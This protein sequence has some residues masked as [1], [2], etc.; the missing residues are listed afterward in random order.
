MKTA[1]ITGGGGFIG[2]HLAHLLLTEG[3]R[4]RVLDNFS[5][6]TPTNL[7]ALSGP[8]D[9]IN[10]DICDSD[11]C[12]AAT[13]GVDSV[14]H[15][16]A[17]A[18]VA[19]SV[20]DPLRS[21]A[22]NLTGTVQ[23]LQAAKEAGVRR[24]VFSS[25]ASVY[26]NAETVPT[27]EDQLI[28]PLSPY[29]STK[30]SGEMYCRNYFDL[31]GMETVILRYFNVFGPRQSVSSGYAAAIPIFIQQILAGKTPTIYGDGRQTRDFVYVEDV[32]AAN[33]RAALA[34]GVGGQVFNIAGGNS[35]TLLDLMSVLGDVTG[36]AVAPHF[37]PARSGD[38]R[39]SRADISR[40]RALLGYAPAVSFTEGIC[41][42][43][44]QTR[45][46]APAQPSVKHP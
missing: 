7:L 46:A 30:A 32:A 3:W 5:T 45:R 28:A 38:V 17:I 40:A 33:L 1:L 41:R 8:L 14:F 4:V 27:V 42:T 34:P 21:H 44:E 36:A 37:A 31:F 29:A 20:A 13:Q 23:V 12:H 26:G 24:F 11:V 6:G 9:V 2:N 22:V 19:A 43:V 15:L 39:H 18:S 35:I 10:G 16:A 25:S